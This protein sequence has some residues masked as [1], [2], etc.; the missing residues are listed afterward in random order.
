MKKE[1]LTAIAIVGALL[2]A[3]F[4]IQAQMVSESKRLSKRKQAKV[5]R[6]PLGAAKNPV[7]C[8]HPEGERAYLDRLRCESGKP[9]KYVRAGS[10]GE[11]PYGTIMDRYALTCPGEETTRGVFMDMYHA[12]FIENQPVPGFSIIKIVKAD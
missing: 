11:G 4:D 3:G 2:I 6:E 8:A 1:V 7:R 12:G 5:D 9:P 10:V